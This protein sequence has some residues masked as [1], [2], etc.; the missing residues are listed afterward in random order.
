[1]S[2]GGG[3]DSLRG[4]PLRVFSFILDEK[5]SCWRVLRKPHQRVG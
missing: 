5:R 4:R 3:A 1:M 2:G